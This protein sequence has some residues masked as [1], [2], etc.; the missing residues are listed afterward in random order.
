MPKTKTIYICDDC[1]AESPR[2]AGKCSNCGAWN[3]LKEMRI[4]RALNP[5]SS[6]LSIPQNLKKISLKNQKRIR[7]GI[8]EFDRV[9]GGGIVPGSLVLLAGDPGIG[10]STLL[11]Q[12]AESVENS[13]YVSGEESIYQIKLRAERLEISENRALVLDEI[14][15]EKIIET[16]KKEKPTIL[17]IDSI[18]TMYDPESETSPG[19]VTQVKAVGLKIQQFAK[20]SGIPVIIIGHITKSGA[21]AGPRTLE[22]LVD[23]VL[24]FEGD[25][26]HGQRILRATKNRFGSTFESGVF[27]MTNRGLKEVKNPSAIFVNTETPKA[28]GSATTVT[29]EGSRPFLFEVQALCPRSVF[30]YAKRTASGIDLSR[31]QLLAAVV[32]ENTK[33]NLQS[34]DVYVNLVGGVKVRE[35]ATDLAICAALISAARRKAMP[36]FSAIMGEVGL[37][38]EVREITLVEKRI[39]EASRQG[40]TR[41]FIPRTRKSYV[42]RGV[43]II[44]LSSLKELERFL[45]GH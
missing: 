10:K 15:I 20:I 30:G 43:K 11:L 28:P 8:N 26:Y 23:T 16:T 33:I 2:W 37:T 6:E 35:P 40:Y 32:T 1:G 24:Y 34:R 21:V 14:D 31:V 3:T 29:I 12:I 13:L 22:H 41:I 42:S 7:T 5:R 19:N 9:V 44:Q 45:V 39:I 4:S 17:I 38:G 36:A 18:Q 25:K 27:E